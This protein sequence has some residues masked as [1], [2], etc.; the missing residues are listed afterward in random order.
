LYAFNVVKTNLGSFR[1]GWASWEAHVS[2]KL[3][4]INDTPA[5]V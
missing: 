2:D 4:N 5:Q 3:A 1:P